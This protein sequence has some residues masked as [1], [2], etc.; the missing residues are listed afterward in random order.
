MDSGEGKVS[1]LYDGEAIIDISNDFLITNSSNPIGS[2]IA[3]VYPFI[4]QNA[5]NVMFFFQERAILAMKNE[6]VQEINDR[7]ISIIFVI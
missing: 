5:K 6:V 2:L 4:I 3:F 1:G 7:L